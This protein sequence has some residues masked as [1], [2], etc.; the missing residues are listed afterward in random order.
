MIVT[1]YFFLSIQVLL[2]TGI[3]YK[4]TGRP[5]VYLILYTVISCGIYCYT[6]ITVI[7]CYISLYICIISGIGSPIYGNPFY[8]L[9]KWLN[10]STTLCIDSLWSNTRYLVIY[11]YIYLYYYLYCYI[12]IIV[13]TLFTPHSQLSYI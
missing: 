1:G 11:H 5:S 10:I 7:Y 9:G 4:E 6:V 13:E 2:D 8:P 12:Y 3:A